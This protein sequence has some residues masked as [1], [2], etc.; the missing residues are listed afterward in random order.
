M[1]CGGMASLALTSGLNPSQKEAV[2]HTD[3]PL[4][5][6]A[7]AGSGKTRVLTHRI[8]YLIAERGISPYQILA[9]TFTKKAAEEMK[10][11][12]ENLVGPSYPFMWVSTFHSACARMLRSK[13]KL[14]GYGSDYTI[15][16][17]TDVKTLTKEALQVVGLDGKLA[18]T[19]QAL[20]SKAKNEAKD[21]LNLIEE[22]NFIPPN[23]ETVYQTYEQL[24]YE[25]NA[26]DF[27]DL[28]SNTVKLLETN[29]EILQEY[30]K[31]FSYVLVD[32]YQDTNPVQNKLITLLSKEHRNICVVGD[33]D[34]SIY[35]FRS[36]DIRNILHFEENFPD[37]TV[38]PLE[39]NYRSTQNI[40]DAA[41]SVID[42]NHRLYAKN[43]WTEGEMG[44]QISCIHVFN[45]KD[46]AE[47]IGQEIEHMESGELVNKNPDWSGRNWFETLD[48]IAVFY[49]TNAQSRALE[50]VLARKKIS[51]KV[52]GG[53]R[54]YERKE[55][56]DALAYLTVLVNPREDISLDRVLNL[57]TR[58]LGKGAKAILNEYKK[59]NGLQSLYEVL[60]ESQKQ[61]VIAAEVNGEKKQLSK[62][63]LNGI[64]QFLQP[65]IS[66]R[67]LIEHDLELLQSPDFNLKGL[68]IL[69]EQGYLCPKLA[70]SHLLVETGYLKSLEKED[71]ITAASRMENLTE[72]LGAADDQE[73]KQDLS[74][75]EELQGVQPEYLSAIILF[76]VN[77]TLTDSSEDHESGSVSLMSLHSSKGLE[78][79]A[80]FIMGMEDEVFPHQRSIFEEGG[81]E[82]EHRLAYV[83]ITRAEKKLYLTHAHKR[84]LHG[85][86]TYNTP[87]RFI[88]YIPDRLIT[89]SKSRTFEREMSDRVQNRFGSESRL[90]GTKAWSLSTPRKTPSQ[91]H[92]DQIG[93][94]IGDDVN[95]DMFG[96]G[97]IVK[98]EV[99]EYE[100]IATIN[101]V[102][103]GQKTLDLSWAPVRKI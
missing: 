36:A 83:G 14:L 63:A 67:E 21:P 87:S 77:S 97:V 53:L 85:Q 69:N 62:Q 80:V 58:G 33:P 61:T 57:P 66:L 30:Q 47:V 34:Q 65:Y 84:M 55:I 59:V 22:L 95:H 5:V 76:L 60:E 23:F 56:K 29:E 54:F 52:I 35:A 74:Q 75:R 72:L 13:A 103:E 4:L 99:T 50:E 100:A 17:Q 102:D 1:Y 78:Y 94:Q 12:V 38:I 92:A 73:Y 93:L 31:K 46:E 9:I 42:Q 86:T 48:D 3:G 20:I 43:L 70:L 90:G 26:M 28:L 68:N 40:L 37:T 27:D 82:E 8:A 49:R 7:G 24:K 10:G 6:L 101:F 96:D 15:Y 39:Q 16:D 71:P 51:Y 2:T 32:E 64:K 41:N 89:H 79:P 98:L 25:N 11:R 44:E 81:L 18:N 91:S 19:Y 45:E 88:G